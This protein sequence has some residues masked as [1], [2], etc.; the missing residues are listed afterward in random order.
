[1]WTCKLTNFFTEN[2]DDD[3]MPFTTL[4][5]SEAPERPCI[6]G[7]SYNVT[8]LSLKGQTDLCYKNGFNQV[9][10]YCQ[11]PVMIKFLRECSNEVR[12]SGNSS[13]GTNFSCP[14]K[15]HEKKILQPDLE[16]RQ[17]PLF[18][19]VGQPATAAKNVGLILEHWPFLFKK[20][21]PIQG[22]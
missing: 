13:L 17:S 7:G 20:A 15:V 19:K 14:Q 18:M 11:D 21:L 16:S 3:N 2:M 10:I 8:E 6:N 1:M 4:I 12:D 5:N 9:S 22:I